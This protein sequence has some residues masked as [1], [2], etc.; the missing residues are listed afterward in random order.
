MRPF[1]LAALLAGS[2]AAPAVAQQAEINPGFTGPRVG[3]IV[4]YG[5]LGS[6]ED[7]EAGIE[8]DGRGDQSIEGVTYGVDGG[9]DFAIGGL[10]A[11]VEAEYSESSGRQDIDESVALPF[12]GR[13]ETGRDLYVG[14][15][16]GFLATPQTLLYGKAG[17]T[18]TSIESAFEDADDRFEFDTN[19][20]GYRLG[21]GVEQLFGEKF[22]GKLEYRYSNY[23]KLDFSDD[24]DQDFQTS[25]DA[26]RHQVVAGLG[27]RF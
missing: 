4:G 24:D 9:F 16:L 22:Y 23:S 26:D 13:I 18:N 21:A 25:I 19:I 7:P 3:G 11:G 2:V 1:I 27:I 15:R 10:V 14:G 5:Q 17:Y 12:S 8:N 20:D 6:G